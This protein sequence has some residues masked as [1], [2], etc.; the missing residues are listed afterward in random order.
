M[1]LMKCGYN[2]LDE[3]AAF[4]GR[5]VNHLEKTVN[6]PKWTKNYPNRE[7]VEASICRGEQYIYV[8]DGKVAG[9]VVLNE[10]PGGDYEAGDWSVHL[11]RGEYLVIHTFAVEPAARGKGLGSRMADACIDIAR[12]EGYKAIRLDV[13]PGNAPAIHLYKRKGFTY[14]G[15]KDLSRKIEDIPVFELYE[16]NI[17]CTRVRDVLEKH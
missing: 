13:V 5:V 17:A 2:Y 11:S 12:E 7:S 6:Y 3:T 14:A 16:L 10:E 9:A 8:D 15:T 1:G 4:Y